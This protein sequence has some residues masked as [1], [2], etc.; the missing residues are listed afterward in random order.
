MNMKVHPKSYRP[1]LFIIISLTDVNQT[2]TCFTNVTKTCFAFVC[3]NTC[4]TLF[5]LVEMAS[6]FVVYHH[7]FVLRSVSLVQKVA[8]AL[9]LYLI[10][11]VDCCLVC[12]L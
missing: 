10:H 4:H 1:Y 11:L 9:P 12:V 7:L 6:Y 8:V 2:E 5:P 3:V